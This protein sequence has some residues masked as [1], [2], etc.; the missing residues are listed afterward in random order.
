MIEMKMK[1]RRLKRKPAIVIATFGSTSIGKKVYEVFEKEVIESFPEHKIFWAYTSEII[2]AKTK[3]IGIQQALAEA[4]AD[5]YRKIVVQPLHIFPGTEYQIL[6]EIC[7]TFPGIRS[8]I[9]ETLLHRWY[10][11]DEV[12][13]LISK[14]FIPPSEGINLLIAHGTPLAADPVNVL[15][16]GLEYLL[17]K[18]FDNV[19]LCSIEGIP[20]RNTV[21]KQIKVSLSSENKKLLKARLLP[22]MF[23]AGKHVEEDLLGEED[24]YAKTLKTMG[25]E[26]EILNSEIEGKIYPKGLGFYKEVRKLFIERI[27]RSLELMKF[28]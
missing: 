14:D 27:K 26:V 6:S 1:K 11:V 3:H 25:L 16:L 22:F 5:G 18:R 15:Y 28:Y 17:R 19:Y 20:D 23:V 21:F 10:F 2:R 8:I 12:I 4:E 9:G 7:R 24:S 13:R